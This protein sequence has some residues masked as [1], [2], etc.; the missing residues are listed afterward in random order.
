VGLAC[1]V[2]EIA[3]VV[4]AAA[5]NA[6]HTDACSSF[7]VDTPHY[8]YYVGLEVFRGGVWQDTPRTALRWTLTRHED[9]SA[10]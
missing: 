9:V 2:V 5:G 7:A 4:V 3:V 6:S 10:W 1:V 8:L